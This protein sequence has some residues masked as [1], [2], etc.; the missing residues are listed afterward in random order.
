VAWEKYLATG[1]VNRVGIV[2]DI[3]RESVGDALMMRHENTSIKI[4]QMLGTWTWTC[5]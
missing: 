2:R 5:N 1:V 4:G 3:F